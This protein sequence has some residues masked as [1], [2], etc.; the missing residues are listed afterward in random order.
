L[1][2]IGYRS[3]TF[4]SHCSRN[5][6]YSGKIPNGFS[7]LP[8]LKDKHPSRGVGVVRRVRAQSG[9]LFTFHDPR[10]TFLTMG[11]KLDVPPYALKRLVNHS[12]S[13]DM[14]GRYLILDIERLRSHMARITNAFLA[15]LGIDG[16]NMINWK[17]VTA[18]DLTEVTRLLIPLNDV[19]FM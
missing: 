11:E 9:I 12:V 19:R 6:T 5:A 10:R 4:W 8:R 15:L 1:E 2:S 13:N 7:N 3:A 18:L 14:T 17:P 16:G